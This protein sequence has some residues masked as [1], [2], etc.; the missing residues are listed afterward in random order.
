MFYSNSIDTKIREFII[1]REGEI[2][3]FADTYIFEPESE[4]EKRYGKLLLVAEITPECSQAQAIVEGIAEIVQKQYYKGLHRDVLANFEAALNKVNEILAELAESGAASWINHLHAVM[5]VIIGDSLHIANT[6]KADAL[7]IRD[8]DIASIKPPPAIGPEDQENPFKTF[9]NVTSGKIAPGDRVLLVTP[10]IFNYLSLERILRTIDHYAIEDASR[11]FQTCLYEFRSDCCV[12]GILFEASD[13]ASQNTVT[14][15]AIPDISPPEAPPETEIS[16]ATPAPT[17]SWRGIANKWIKRT[18]DHTSALTARVKSII[19]SRGDV[20][21]KQIYVSPRERRA[22]LRSATANW[23]LDKF[24]FLWRRFLR[25]PLK[26]RIL[27]VALVVF[28]LFFIIS[29]AVAINRASPGNTAG[30]NKVTAESVTNTLNDVEAA[31]IYNDGDRTASLL[32]QAVAD[33]AT[34]KN[35][36][37]GDYSALEAQLTDLERRSERTDLASLTQL[38]DFN[39]VLGTPARLTGILQSGN[40]LYAI[41]GNARRL[42]TLNVVTNERGVIPLSGEADPA[43]GVT[44]KNNDLIL[45]TTTPSL[46][47]VSNNS[48]AP[49]KETFANNKIVNAIS[50]AAYANNVYALVPADSAIYL[51][52]RVEEGYGEAESW[53]KD[54]AVSLHDAISLA[55]DGSAYILKGNNEV[56]KLFRGAPAEFSLNNL[57]DIDKLVSIQTFENWNSL[58]LFDREGQALIITDKNGN[59]QKRYRWDEA[60]VRQILVDEP[61]RKAYLMSDT[62]IFSFP[63]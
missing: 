11:N 35:Q 15:S 37:P 26:Q 5:A 59:F 34:L 25:L 47:K 12:A 8:G 19:P 38:A 23:F 17:R 54:S 57:P 9:S 32:A 36:A 56:L 2:K 60:S 62:V 4:R 28:A 21:K 43:L 13:R 39:E 1:T 58:Y 3:G 6:G 42:L 46:L 16:P 20:A 52:A 24:R 40:I 51:F 41:D 33:L 53:I 27:I 18:K 22:H 63:L 14:P 61:G 55:I 49:I 7:L 44:L 50:L 31:L 45:L 10:G 29:T 30:E 48:L